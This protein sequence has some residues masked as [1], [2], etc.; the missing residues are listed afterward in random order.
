MGDWDFLHEMRDRGYSQEAI[1]GA[2]ACGY[3]PWEAVV[4][5]HFFAPPSKTGPIFLSEPKSVA[6]GG[7]MPKIGH[8]LKL[9]RHPAQPLI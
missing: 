1:T 9:A 4:K 7:Q 8:P 3:A 5:P 6:G 2:M